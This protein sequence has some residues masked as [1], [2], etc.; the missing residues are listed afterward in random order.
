[1]NPDRII[2]LRP[3]I[4]VS[5]ICVIFAVISVAAIY[6]EDLWVDDLHTIGALSDADTFIPKL[7]NKQAPTYYTIARIWWSL[8]NDSVWWLRSLSIFF[9][10]ATVPVVYLIGK[11]MVSNS[12]GVL[13]AFIFIL[14]PLIINHSYN[15]RP[16]ALYTFFAATAFLFIVSNLKN[17]RSGGEHRIFHFNPFHI[18]WGVVGIWAGITLSMFMVITS[19]HAGALFATV[20]GGTYG[21]LWLIYREQRRAVLFSILYLCV[22]LTVIAA[23]YV[24]FIYGNFAE[25]ATT[26]FWNGD[27]SIGR[28]IR[29]IRQT[30]GGGNPMIYAPP[31]LVLAVA[32]S[33]RFWRNREYD[34][35]ILLL[36]GWLVALPLL[37][38]ASWVIFPVFIGRVII[39]TLIPF[40]LMLGIGL[41]ALP[42]RW[43]IGMVSVIAALGIFVIIGLVTSTRIPWT[44][45]TQTIK[46]EHRPGD[47]IV[48]CWD[49][50][51]M[52]L[53][54]YLEIGTNDFWTYHPAYD[55]MLDRSGIRYFNR[56]TA[57]GIEGTQR[58]EQE[59]NLDIIASVPTMTPEE[60]SRTYDRAWVM[61]RRANNETFVQ[62]CI[63]NIPHERV[64]RYEYLSGAHDIY[65]QLLGHRKQRAVLALLDLPGRQGEEDHDYE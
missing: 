11:T 12:A 2:H 41:S 24:P 18:H 65:A 8:G 53:V 33:I 17:I 13:S 39:W 48:P 14:H 1:M 26:G 3:W 22:G 57:R 54:H 38:I 19:H 32:A 44:D 47:A 45:I 42:G 61:M 21:L 29:V 5:V 16:Y 6:G 56:D 43:R 7:S 34:W 37:Q 40:S 62:R 27:D 52:Q 31:W 55:L 63:T 36:A 25:D 50:S 49:H 58:N 51:L 9:M 10:L 59:R 23:I 15:I 35:A 28:A 30:Y 64:H 4:T 20:I 46:Q 60:F